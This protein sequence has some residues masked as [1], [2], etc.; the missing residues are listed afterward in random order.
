M[1]MVYSQNV[2]ATRNRYTLNETMVKTYVRSVIAILWLIIGF[3]CID[4]CDGMPKSAKPLWIVWNSS[5]FSAE[6]DKNTFKFLNQKGFIRLFAF[7]Y[8]PGL[9][10]LLKSMIKPYYSIRQLSRHIWD[11]FFIYQTDSI[12]SSTFSL[13]KCRKIT[14]IINSGQFYRSCAGIWISK[15]ISNFFKNNSLGFEMLVNYLSWP[16]RVEIQKKWN[17]WKSSQTW[18]N[19]IFQHFDELPPVYHYFNGKLKPLL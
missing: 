6:F 13:S 12:F 5:I 16:R 7:K 4:W 14:I 17:T 15:P 11:L 19:D 10:L 9:S 1:F 8:E 3:F 2:L 18:K